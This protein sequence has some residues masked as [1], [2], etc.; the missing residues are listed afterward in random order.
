MLKQKNK[1]TVSMLVLVFAIGFF[2]SGC[3]MNMEEII[4]SQEESAVSDDVL[5]QIYTNTPMSFLKFRDIPMASK[6]VMDIAKS[7]IYGDPYNWTGDLFLTA[8][9]TFDGMFDFYNTEMKRFAWMPLGV[10]KGKYT[11]M[12]FL[13]HR[14]VATMQI[15]RDDEKGSQIVVTMVTAPR[16]MED[17]YIQYRIDEIRRGRWILQRGDVRMMEE[18]GML[19]TDEIRKLANE[20][21]TQRRG[22][23]TVETEEARRHQIQVMRGL[24]ENP[25]DAELA[26]AGKVVPTTAVSSEAKTLANE[27]KVEETLS[28]IQK[29]AEQKS[30]EGLNAP[31]VIAPSALTPTTQTSEDAIFTD[32][33]PSAPASIDISKIQPMPMPVVNPLPTA[34]VPLAVEPTAEPAPAPAENTVQ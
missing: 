6:T 34:P 33:P 26:A 17:Y 19:V 2:T 4:G 5:H 14:R 23:S 25:S 32:N 9:Y 27:K 18:K 15:T 20:N 12:T 31:M 7:S 3:E 10:V 13:R 22:F 8:P 28:Q 16:N 24:I 21:A 29:N 30:E 1:F 11:I